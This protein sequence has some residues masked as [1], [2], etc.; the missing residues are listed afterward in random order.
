MERE[1][2]YLVQALAEIKLSNL[3]LDEAISR[4]FLAERQY[5]LKKQELKEFKGRHLLSVSWENINKKRKEEGLSP[6][7]NESSRK[8]YI[9]SLVCDREREVIELEAKY[10]AINEYLQFYIKDDLHGF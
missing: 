5:K 2:N 9:D 4:L 7:S 3:D 6:I 1:E 10:H 8:A